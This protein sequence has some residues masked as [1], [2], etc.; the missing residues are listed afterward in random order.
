MQ[1]DFVKR[2]KL[3]SALRYVRI[4]YSSVI[5][6]QS[7]GG[8]SP[9]PPPPYFKTKLGRKKIFWR[10]PPT[11]PPYLRVWTTVP[12][13]L[14]WGSVSSSAKWRGVIRLDIIQFAVGLL[15]IYFVSPGQADRHNA[16]DGN[17]D[18]SSTA[19]N[20][21]GIENLTLCLSSRVN[22]NIWETSVCCIPKSI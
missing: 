22:Q 15:H 5:E 21:Q 19:R 9:P 18:R 12:P 4:D 3:K 11:P 6:H 2:C 14:T 13:P 1:Q 16:G 7:S 20:R 10:P 17:G 8:S